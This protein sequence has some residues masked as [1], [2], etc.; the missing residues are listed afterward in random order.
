[1]GIKSSL[2]W[3]ATKVPPPI[4]P[5]LVGLLTARSSARR[6]G[7]S[8]ESA[9]LSDDCKFAVLRACQDLQGQATAVFRAETMREAF[10]T[11]D[12]RVLPKLRRALGDERVTEFHIVL[13]GDG[14]TIVQRKIDDEGTAA[15]EPG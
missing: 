1:M 15:A 8:S 5:W 12:L 3:L 4:G 13:G 14:S 11:D 2:I 6:A 9:T 10:G 7:T